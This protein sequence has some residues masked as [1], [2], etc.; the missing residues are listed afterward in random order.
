MTRISRLVHSL[1]FKV[2][3][4]VLLPLLSVLI[5]LTSVRHANYQ[6]RLMQ[7]LADAAANAGEIIE[8]SLQQAMLTNDF[9]ML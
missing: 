6:T 8:G 9:T 2:T 5:A 7:N 1:R 4:G 3:V